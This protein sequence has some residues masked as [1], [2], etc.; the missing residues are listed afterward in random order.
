MAVFRRDRGE[1]EEKVPP[2]PRQEPRISGPLTVENLERVFT[3]CVDFAKRQV[4]LGA[5]RPAGPPCAISP[6]W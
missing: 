3:D 4:A 1:K 5:I 6:V 2:H